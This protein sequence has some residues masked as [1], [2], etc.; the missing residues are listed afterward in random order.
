[1]SKPRIPNQ[2]K[3]NLAH[4]R[5]VEQYAVF[6]QQ[7]YD[8]MAKEAVRYAV[9]AGA[10][11]E[12]PFS[13]SDYPL[14]KEAIRQLQSQLMNDVSA[15]IMRGT[16]EEW[17][18]SNLVQDLVA[19]K[20]LTA[21][22]G[23]S[24]QGDE[25]SRYFETNPDALKNFQER[26]DRG[27]NLSTRVWNLSEQYKSELEEAITAAIAPGTSAMSLAAQ[28]KQY[29]KYPDKRFRR[30]KEKLADGTIKWHLS[31][32]AKAFHPG[33]G[34]PG[35]YRSSARNAQR[36]ARTEINMSYRT[37]EQ[38]RWEQF[39]FVVGYEIKTTQNGHH[40]TDICDDLKG[41]YP[42]SFKFTGWHPQ[43]MC[44][45][46]PILKTEYEFWADDDVKSV[47]EVTDVP[48]NFKQWIIDNEERINA[49]EKRGNLPYFISDNR[50]VVEDVLYPKG[51]KKNSGVDAKYHSIDDVIQAWD[52]NRFEERG[53]DE[54]EGV[55]VQGYVGELQG[56]NG[57]PNQLS[58][59]DFNFC[60]H[61]DNYVVMYRGFRRN[62]ETNVENFLHGKLYEGKGGAGDGSYF[63]TNKNEVLSAYVSDRNENHIITAAFDKRKVKIANADELR[64]QWLSEMNAIDKKTLRAELKAKGLKGDTYWDA[65]DALNDKL[66]IYDNFGSWATAKG[67]DL[68]YNPSDGF[69]IVLNRTKIYVLDKTLDNPHYGAAMKLGRTATK[70]AMKIVEDIGVPELTEI[71]K[72]NI[73]ELADALGVPRKEI[74]PMSFLDADQGA[75]NPTKDKENC[76]S[77]VVAFEARRRGLNCHA[78]PYSANRNS[79]SYALG[80]RFQDAWINPKTNKIIE[81]TIIKGTNDAE[82]ISKLKR[83]LGTDGRYVLG[84]NENNGRGHL[85][86]IERVNGRI[87]IKDDQINDFIAI[88]S[89]EDISYLEI[90]KIDRA[91][92]NISKIKS[93]LGFH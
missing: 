1:M 11:D 25:Y 88:D 85:V 58:E 54:I 32:N 70:E 67:Y 64:E 92:L 23:T 46:I 74:K 61:D 40:V 82:I 65:W 87:I 59:P 37:A 12:K 93:I 78:L 56:F 80:E 48:K 4:K 73:H 18:E 75:S 81:P 63:S 42:K 28:V 21:Y 35:V 53:R 20:V 39:D 51:S 47:N 83:Q 71:Q 9:L 68:I 31:K 52:S 17:K 91:I 57:L 79:E 76:Q 90:I 19:K 8:H 2:R 86:S 60:I 27:M 38:K 77:V 33:N 50:E 3:A 7:V 10:N 69:Y 24:K 36:L 45:C 14:T 16:S 22:A 6:I 5:R 13:F 84:I 26:K 66:M 44:Y 62:A 30:I 29:L 41:K 72:R 15:I 34:K 43:C 49:A 55:T 89:L